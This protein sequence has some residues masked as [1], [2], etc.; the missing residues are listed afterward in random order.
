[1]RITRR[2]LVPRT[3]TQRRRVPAWVPLLQVLVSLLQYLC[4]GYHLDRDHVI[5]HYDITGKLCP[6]YYCEHPEEWEALKDD[7][8]A[9]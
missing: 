7:V 2:R 3:Q 4:N 6:L 8:F 5:R 1:M 9:R